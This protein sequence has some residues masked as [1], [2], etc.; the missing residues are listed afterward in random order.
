MGYSSIPLEY[1]KEKS[2]KVVL[3]LVITFG[4]MNIVFES[5]HSQELRPYTL[6]II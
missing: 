3:Y 2:N 4:L 1:F 6:H 5:E